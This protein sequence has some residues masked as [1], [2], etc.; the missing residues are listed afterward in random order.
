MN[1]R[2]LYSIF[3][4][5]TIILTI[6]AIITLIPN[7]AASKPNLFG[8]K[9][10]CS[11]TP[12]GTLILCLL[13]GIVCTIRTGVKEKRT[14]API[15]IIILS[16]VLITWIIISLAI[17]SNAKSGFSESI[18][19]TT[20]TGKFVIPVEN[21][22]LKGKYQTKEVSV[23][24]LVT[25]KNGKITEI[26]LLNG[27]NI[28]K[29]V[30]SEIFKRIISAQNPSVDEISGATASCKAIMKAVELSLSEK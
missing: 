19:E 15:P 8:Y 22:E 16:I 7:P 29:S 30:S 3:L 1:R 6:L 27:K 17:Y 12:A 26:K 10:I 28:D 4:V 18:T 2:T 25:V 11:F 20:L 24:V 9:S 21:I 23:E 14:G 5:L 13:A